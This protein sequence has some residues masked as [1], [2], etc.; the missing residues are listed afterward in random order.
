M[1][2]KISKITKK[3]A[4]IDPVK[5]KFKKLRTFLVRFLVLCQIKIFSLFY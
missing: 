2:M 1:L 3:M 4:F 5:H